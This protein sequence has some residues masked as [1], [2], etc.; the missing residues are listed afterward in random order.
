MSPPD[1]VTA[2]FPVTFPITISP[3][4]VLRS[5]SPPI[6]PVVISPPEVRISIA[7]VR[8]PRRT[9]PPPVIPFILPSSGPL[10]SMSPFEDWSRTSNLGGRLISSV[11][12]SDDSSLSSIVTVVPLRDMAMP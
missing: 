11:M 9:F 7:P 8:F 6:S 1:V 10:I 2:A 5:R 3:P 12:S 4:D